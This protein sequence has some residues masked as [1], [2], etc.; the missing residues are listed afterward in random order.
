MMKHHKLTA[1][2]T[3]GWLRICRPG[4]VI[5]QQQQYMKSMQ[6]KLWKE[7]DL[8]EARMRQR[9]LATVESVSQA[10][11]DL[12]RQSS[13]NKSRRKLSEGAAD[14]TNDIGSMSL[15]SSLARSS[16]GRD[17][18]DIAN[19]EAEGVEATQGD[20]L[21]LQRAAAARSHPSAHA[22]SSTSSSSALPSIY[23]STSSATSVSI[24]TSTSTTPMGEA[25]ERTRTPPVNGGSPGGVTS[26]FSRGVKNAS[27]GTGP[28]ERSST[29]ASPISRFMSSFRD[30]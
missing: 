21:R 26:L 2:E 29:G 22:H 6:S 4:S 13:V 19:E 20:L 27:G 1:E 8:Y 10:P 9:R 5:G 14:L 28:A 11:A 16:A 17:E 23:V 3:I 18:Q 30:K 7:G 24:T 12:S 15:G 25:G